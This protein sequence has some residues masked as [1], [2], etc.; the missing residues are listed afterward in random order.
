MATLDTQDLK[1]IKTLIEVTLDEK[2]EEGGVVTKQDI[3]FLPTRE[4][5]YKRE[6]KMMSEFKKI[7][8]NIT[9]LSQHSKDHSDEIERLKKIHP[10]YKHQAL[11]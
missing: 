4:E 5:Y 9:V 10:N 2:F 11:Q 1:N 3:S 8:E 7:R 6:D